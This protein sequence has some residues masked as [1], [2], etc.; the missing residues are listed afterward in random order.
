MPILLCSSPK[1]SPYPIYQSHHFHSFQVHFFISANFLSQLW[2]FQWHTTTMTTTTTTTT[3]TT[4]GFLQI[5]HSG[6]FKSR[7]Q[8]W[9]VIFVAA[10]KLTNYCK[11]QSSRRMNF[12]SSFFFFKDVARWKN[13]RNGTVSIVDWQHTLLS[14]SIIEIGA[15]T[16]V[17]RRR[18]HIEPLS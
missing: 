11:E 13:E 2:L 14:A 5:R 15:Y 7:K 9:K 12:S 10:T 1:E 18:T 4:M 8:F 6:S 17:G 16:V 3:T